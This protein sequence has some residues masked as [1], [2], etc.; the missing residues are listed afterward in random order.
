VRLARLFAAVFS[1]SLRRELAYRTDLLFRVLT[2]A[3]GV[4]AGLIALR[5]VYSRTE[6]LAGWSAAEA[7]VLLGTFQIVTG[8]REA[9]VEPNVRWFGEAVK[10][11]RLDETLLKPAPSVFLFSLGSCAPLGLAE[12]ALG[13]AVVVLGLNDLGRS[14]SAWDVLGWLLTLAAAGVVTWASRVLIAC[15]VFWAPDVT[16]DVLY[17]ALW[18]F[19]RYPVGV[20]H[21]PLRFGLTYLLPVA[22]VATLPARVLVRGATPLAAVAAL[23]ASLIGFA[24][25]LAVWE[26]GV[27]RYTGAT[28]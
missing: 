17:D 18:Q 9:F 19:G 22:L 21:E 27:R 28:S 13:L 2:A 26:A 10:Q 12:T 8:L 5:V 6:A 3:I 1:A 16:L 25:V 24:A 11:G 20:F 14:P 4:G 23:A 15:A 7:T